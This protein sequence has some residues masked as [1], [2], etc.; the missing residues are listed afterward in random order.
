V[1]VLLLKT[2]GLMEDNKLNICVITASNENIF[3]SIEIN[4]ALLYFLHYNWMLITG[5]R[6]Q[7]VADPCWSNTW[8]CQV[9]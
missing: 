7:I 3:V 4:C 8:S 1:L 2:I 5:M 9:K 6:Q